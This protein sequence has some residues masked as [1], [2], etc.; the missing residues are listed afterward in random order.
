MKELDKKLYL[1]KFLQTTEGPTNQAMI[2]LLVS[3]IEVLIARE[4]MKWRQCAKKI[5]ILW[6]TRIINFFT[7]V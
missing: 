3:E 6:E 5:N 2:I 1:F 4:D 7:P